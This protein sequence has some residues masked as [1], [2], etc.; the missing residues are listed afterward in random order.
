MRG[1]ILVVDDDPTL[2]AAL[3][4][5]LRAE[6]HEVIEARNGDEAVRA[7]RRDR[8]AL[9]VLDCAMPGMDGEMVLDT[10]GRADLATVLLTTTTEQ[11]RR[12][13]ER[14]VLGL[15]KPF[16]VE[17]LLAAVARHRDRFEG[18]A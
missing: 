4:R 3:G 17:D 14:G 6:G 5:I 15:C 12:A 7:A 16:Q 10:L 9:L 8:P 11:Q 1:P 13:E 2:R 18:A